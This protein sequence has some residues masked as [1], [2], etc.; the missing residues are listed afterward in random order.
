VLSILQQGHQGSEKNCHFTP[1]FIYW[2]A[3]DWPAIDREVADMVKH[4]H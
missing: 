3:I 1:V 4:Y 2:P